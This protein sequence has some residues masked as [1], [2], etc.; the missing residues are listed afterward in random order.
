M[1]CEMGEI[2]DAIKSGDSI[3]IKKIV[4]SGAD[5]NEVDKIGETALMWAVYNDYVDIVKLLIN[6]GA[7]VNVKNKYEFTALIRALK[8]PR[9][10]EILIKGTSFS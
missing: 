1:R 8:N 5:V 9:I 7:D 6:A 10:L 4:K 3:N 2:I